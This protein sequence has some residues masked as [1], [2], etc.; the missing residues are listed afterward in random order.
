MTKEILEMPKEVI[1]GIREGRKRKGPG[2]ISAQ[3]ENGRQ[4]NR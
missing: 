1:W 2:V 4:A 3:W